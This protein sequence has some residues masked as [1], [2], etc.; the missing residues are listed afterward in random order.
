MSVKVKDRHISK[1]HCLYKARELMGYILILTRPREFDKDG[2]HIDKGT[3]F[4]IIQDID[5]Y[6]NSLFKGVEIK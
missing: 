1:Q 5:N 3:C 6:F 4:N 2:V